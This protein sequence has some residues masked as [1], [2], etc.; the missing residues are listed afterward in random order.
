MIHA[1]LI[2]AGLLLLVFIGILALFVYG[3]SDWGNRG[4]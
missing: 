4:Q 3:L 2:V 1:I